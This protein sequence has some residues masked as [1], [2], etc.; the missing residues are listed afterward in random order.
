MAAFGL[1]DLLARAAAAAGLFPLLGACSLLG[2][3]DHLTNFF[4]EIKATLDVQIFKK[5][6]STNLDFRLVHSLLS[7]LLLLQSHALTK[8]LHLKLLA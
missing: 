5:S 3:D 2:H 8:H 6:V 7:R 4:T 1:L